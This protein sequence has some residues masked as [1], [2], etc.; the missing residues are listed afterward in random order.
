MKRLVRVVGILS[1]TFLISTTVLTKTDDPSSGV[2]VHEWGTFTTIAGKDGRPVD[3]LPLDG[4]S[5]LPCFVD[6]LA[7]NLKGSLSGKVRMETPV[8]YFYSPQATTVD[9][10][11]RFR[12]GLITEWFPKAD[13]VRH[14]GASGGSVLAPGMET[15]A[16]WTGVRISPA[17][18]AD[19]PTEPG[20]SHYYRARQTDAAPLQVGNERE[21]F[22]FYRGV[23]NTAP[24][25]VATVSSRGLVTVDNLRSEP[26]P[27]MIL[28]ENQGGQSGYQ[29]RSS[30]D[31]RVTFEPP[32]LDA[33]MATPD[34]ELERA[35][36]AQGL[37]PREA[38]AMVAT[39]RDS[40]FEEGARLFY[41][42]PPRAVESALP[43][44][45]TPRPSDLVRVFVGR[46]EL[47]TPARED[48]VRTALMNGDN[49]ALTKYGRFL[50]PIGRRLLERA[51]PD[52]ARL[53]SVLQSR[54]SMT[55]LSAARPP[56]CQ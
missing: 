9:V 28:F 34:S 37:Y 47:V 51:T 21:K 48:A 31:G 11:V 1:I 35:L 42:L 36:I 55:S 39:W 15:T 23:G 4:P 20:P 19:F 27:T 13:V 41:V 52:R 26:I 43:L 5:D 24:P 54:E 40:W 45:I 22:L 17:S 18:S 16:E 32:T 12:D 6:R 33:D 30:I 44:E 49:A 14:G 3:W 50:E 38:K 25:I 56:A 53:Q 7:L 46:I 29:V 2:I 8:L 10:R